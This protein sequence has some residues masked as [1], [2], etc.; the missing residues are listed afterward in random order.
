[1]P[2]CLSVSMYMIVVVNATILSQ[3]LCL[4]LSWGRDKIVVLYY[5]L[6]ARWRANVGA[7]TG[8]HVSAV[9]VGIAP[10]VCVF[11]RFVALGFGNQEGPL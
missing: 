2:D 11:G 3:S 5:C 6:A 1:M 8:A 10:P 7:M 4:C 9:I